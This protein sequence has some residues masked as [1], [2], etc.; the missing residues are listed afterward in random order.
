MKNGSINE[1]ELNGIDPYKIFHV[2]VNRQ[3]C[4]QTHAEVIKIRNEYD[5]F[6]STVPKVLMEDQA[7]FKIKRSRVKHVKLYIAQN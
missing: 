2:Y 6:H 4:M 1:I 3:T 5:W 7:I